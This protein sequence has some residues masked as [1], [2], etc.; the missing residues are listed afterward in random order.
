MGGLTVCA[1]ASNAMLG[2][3]DTMSQETHVKPQPDSGDGGAGA[4]IQHAQHNDQPASTL[5]GQEPDLGGKHKVRT[6]AIYSHTLCT[7]NEG[8]IRKG[9]G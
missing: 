2:S 7:P 9:E 8:N 1:H 6:I 3:I 4:N 5:E